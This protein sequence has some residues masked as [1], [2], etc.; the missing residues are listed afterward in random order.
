MRKI[1]KIILGLIVLVLLGLGAIALYVKTAL[2]NIGEAPNLTV[3]LTETRIERGRYL[4]NAVIACMDCHSKRDWS[5]Y[6]APIMEGTFGGGGEKFGPEIQFPGTVYSPNLTP[7]NLSNWTDGE[8]FR[9]ITTG[10]TKHDKA[11]FPLMGYQSYG[12]MDPED[13]YSVIA[14]LR[15]LKSIENDIP[16][17]DLD[18]PVNFIVNT[19]PAKAALKTKPATT[20][21]VAYGA[22]LVSIANCKDCHS[23]FDSKGGLIPGTEYS[24][25]RIFNFPNGIVVTAPNITFDKETG[26]GTW[27][28]ET[29]IQK[30]KQYSDTTY[31]LPKLGPNDFNTPMPWTMY[32]QIDSNDLSAMYHYLKSLNP[33]S[34]KVEKFVKQGK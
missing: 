34:N 22:Y 18:F 1:F 11:I 5:V 32:T 33:I 15:T 23:K 9:A 20:D 12:K 3:E 31:H 17:P 6:S 27:P 7:Y 21:K 13:V 29:F 10:Q 30:F 8:I 16:P 4:A 24:G 19:M 28:E 14:Y 26:L 25:G 2:P